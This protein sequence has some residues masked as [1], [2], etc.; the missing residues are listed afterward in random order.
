MAVQ[1]LLDRTVTVCSLYIAPSNH[2]NYRELKQLICQ[3]PH[4]FLILRGFDAH[5]LLWGSS[6]RDSRGVI[7]RVLTSTGVCILNNKQ[8]AYYSAATN[9]FTA[10]DLSLANPI[11]HDYF[12]WEVINNP[13]ETDH[14]AILLKTNA[15]LP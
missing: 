5:N 1:L 9:T 12:E 3:L 10:I 15:P 6:S 11:L 8:P 2:L 14:F 13:Y 4:P 7:E